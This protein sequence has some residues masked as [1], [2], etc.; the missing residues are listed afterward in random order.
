MKITTQ[1]ERQTLRLERLQAVL[2]EV[3]EYFGYKIEP[4]S[5][6]AYFFIEKMPHIAKLI[7]ATDDLLCSA[8]DENNGILD[9]AMTIDASKKTEGALF[10]I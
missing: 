1:I 6:D 4:N 10:M 9:L 3:S 5:T 7:D 2:I 8:I